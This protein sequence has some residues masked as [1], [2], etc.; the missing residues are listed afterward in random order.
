MQIVTKINTKEIDRYQPDT[1]AVNLEIQIGQEKI[2]RSLFTYIYRHSY[3]LILLFSLAV[4]LAVSH[5]HAY[6]GTHAPT[7]T[8]TFTSTYFCCDSATL[9]A[10]GGIQALLPGVS[11]K[12]MGKIFS[13]VCKRE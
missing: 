3:F 2:Y 5:E 7:F 9:G 8:D 10:K 12:D 11:N 4:T 6:T 13:A 1:K